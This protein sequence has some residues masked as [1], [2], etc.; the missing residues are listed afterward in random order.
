MSLNDILLVVAALVPA[1][2]LCVYIFIKDRVEKEPI[3]LLLGLFGLGVV[4]CFPAATLEGWISPI[5]DN[6]FS[7]FIYEQN[8]GLYMNETPYRIYTFFSNF[9]GVAL[10]EEG[11]KFLVMYFVTRKNKN[12]NS[13][14]DGLVYAVF[15]SLGFAAFENVLYVLDFGWETAIMRA[16]MSVPGHM[17]FAVMM[18]YYYSLWFVTKQARKLEIG[19]RERGLIPRAMEDFSEKKYMVLCLVVPIC[20]HGFYDYCCNYDSNLATIALFALIIGLYI[21][22]FK[23]INS[24]SKADTGTI[25]FAMGMMYKKYPQLVELLNAA[26]AYD[27]ARRAENQANTTYNTTNV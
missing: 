1:I 6:I 21:Y 17:F 22:C 7:A 20:I 25:N 26:A 24:F 10:I 12:F 19:F 15:V 13:L 5:I 14:F 23:K 4:I 16:V 27:A 2:V 3:G 8:G 18:G 11:L 9:I